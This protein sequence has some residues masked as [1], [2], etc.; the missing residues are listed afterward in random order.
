MS[1]L[2]IA[3]VL[4]LG[5]PLMGLACSKKGPPTKPAEPEARQDLP[6]I[7]ITRDRALIFTYR[8]GQQFRTVER[9]DDV[10][11]GARGWVRVQDP[12]RPAGTG[13]L[14][15]VADLRKADAKG[16]FPYKVLPRGVFVA[17][18]ALPGPGG[19]RPGPA[20]SAL[21]TVILYSRPGCSACDAARSFLGQRGIAFVEKNVQS[22]PAAAK[23]LAEKARAKGVPSNVVPIL[24][25]NGELV[26]GLDTQKIERLLRS[27]I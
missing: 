15:Y 27:Q 2:R 9:M 20:P 11:A 18:R 10:P 13:D 14:V 4:A 19:A 16:Q 21:G 7:E 22:D 1:G 6:P 3:L 25:V 26:V 12:A 5:V 8:D 24:D 23:E 17:G